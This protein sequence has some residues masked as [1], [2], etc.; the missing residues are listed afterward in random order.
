MTKVHRDVLARVQPR[1]P[2]NL[3]TAYGF[4][5][6]VPQM[7]AKLVDYFSTSLQV[8]LAPLHFPSYERATELERAVFAQE[9]READYVF[10]G[11]GSPSYALS[12]W[13]PLGLAD[14]LE[15]VL[16]RGGAVCFASAAALTLGAYTAPIYEIYKVG[17]DAPYWLEGLDLMAR[18]G[19]TCVV[20]PHFDNH[21]GQNYDTRYCYL[22]ERNL[23]ELEDQLPPGV[24][25]LG[26]DEH[27][28]AI[29]DLDD[30]TLTVRGRGHAYWRL[31]GECTTLEHGHQ[32]PLDLLR[33]PGPTARGANRAA[34][35]LEEPREVDELGR[36]ALAGG[37]GAVEAVA[38]LVRR[39]QS[40]GAGFVDPAPLVDALLD[41]RAGAR[42][43]GDFAAADAIRDTLV[44]LGFEVNDGAGGTTWA[45]S[46]G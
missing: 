4:Q 37:P 16:E 26:I 22:G 46:P 33:A 2:V 29:I 1:R 40:G 11:P 34:T 45:R 10:A 20:V 13:R 14:E 27:T 3:D 32:T 15:A 12:Q 31:A 5:G 6:N 25:T 28:A 36:V 43:A 41:A 8:D 21:E 38:H 9:V 19:L 44:R 23:S 39:A 35:P 24:A 17:V 42:R 30:Q 18:L 7:T